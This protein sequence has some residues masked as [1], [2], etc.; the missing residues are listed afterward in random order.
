MNSTVEKAAPAIFVLQ[1]PKYPIVRGEQFQKLRSW[2]QQ[3]GQ[4]M[5]L[6]ISN[7]QPEHPNETFSGSAD[8]WDECKYDR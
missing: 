7:M 1:A 3:L 4:A 8:G 2:E 5:G 6:Q